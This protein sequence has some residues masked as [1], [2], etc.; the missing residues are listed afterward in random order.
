[1]VKFKGIW[2][3]QSYRPDPGSLAADFKSPTFVPW[4]PPG[5]VTIGEDGKT[6]EL[7]FTGMPPAM[8]IK[9]NIQV[10][11]GSPARLSVSAIME[12]GNGQLFTNELEGWFVPAK[13]GEKVGIEPRYV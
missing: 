1:M 3:Y 5:V 8:I 7:K 11:D 10:T 13:L 9:L 4:S 6:G 12:L 2:D